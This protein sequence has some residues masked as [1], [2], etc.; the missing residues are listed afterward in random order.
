M[1]PFNK[2]QQEDRSWSFELNGINVAMDDFFIKDDKH[3]FKNPYK[4]IVYF[5]IEGNLYGLSN[6]ADPKPTAEDLYD[7]MSGQY[8]YFNTAP[9]SDHFFRQHGFV[10]KENG[11]RLELA[12]GDGGKNELRY[13]QDELW[14][15]NNRLL[16]KQ[17]VN[18]G[19]VL[20][21]YT[22]KTGDMLKRIS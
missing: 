21:F 8:A 3:W 7:L 5:N 9:L 20:Y 2:A 1:Y 13:S 22:E 16:K 15:Y 6:L 14:Y 18:I 4:A 19:D 12:D 11:W 10:Q 17:L